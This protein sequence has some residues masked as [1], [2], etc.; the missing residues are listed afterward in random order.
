MYRL[1][2]RNFGTYES[3]LVTHTVQVTQSGASGTQTGL[4]WYEIRNPNGTGRNNP[5]V[6][7][8]Q[9]TFSPDSTTYRW[10]G[11]IA[12]DR[13][14]NML[15]GYSASSSTLF[16]SIRY[17]GRLSTDPLNQME[18]EAEILRG[19]GSQVLG[20]GA[21]RDRWGDY[22]SVAVDP[23]DDCTLWFVSEF[24][25]ATGLAWETHL[26]SFQFPTCH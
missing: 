24:V 6:I 14:G 18:S 25:P 4:R 16:P 10:M 5:P 19:T 7:Y 17:T 2:Y 21:T 20:T 1:S 22:T 13:L 15:L 11:S 12:Q 8:Q 23:V 3:L 26:A 9:S